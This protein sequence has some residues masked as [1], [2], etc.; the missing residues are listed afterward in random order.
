MSSEQRSMLSSNSSGSLGN[1]ATR[2]DTVSEVTPSGTVFLVK[3]MSQDGD[4]L[5]NNLQ[6]S[7]PNA[8][9][10]TSTAGMGVARNG[11]VRTSLHEEIFI[12]EINLSQERNQG[13]D[14]RIN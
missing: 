9:R 8:S 4:T 2:E 7:S 13:G 12:N 6:K 3:Q 11:D 10:G 14:S 5:Q 1:E